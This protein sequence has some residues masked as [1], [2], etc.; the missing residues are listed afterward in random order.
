[1][2]VFRSPVAHAE[3]KGLDL[4]IALKAD[5]VHLVLSFEELVAA[6]VHAG[7]DS[8]LVDNLDGS[9]GAAPFR[10]MLANKRV[11][12]VGEAIAVIIA[13]SPF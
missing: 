4:G 5:G 10:P 8:T 9:K 3:L 2:F 13:E 11:R 7:L 1:M 12:F 6:G